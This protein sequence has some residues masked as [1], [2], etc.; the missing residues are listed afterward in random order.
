MLVSLGKS[1][2]PD[3]P[4]LTQVQMSIPAALL[5]PAVTVSE[6]EGAMASASILVFTSSFAYTFV[7]K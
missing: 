1:L 2:F 4:N 7:R 3:V 5:A 6:T